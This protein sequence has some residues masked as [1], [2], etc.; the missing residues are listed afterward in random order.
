MQ[1]RDISPPVTHIYKEVLYMYLFIICMRVNLYVKLKLKIDRCHL[2]FTFNNKNQ[3]LLLSPVSQI[4]QTRD[5][6]SFSI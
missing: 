2:L 3:F 1:V 5:S 6:I 4:C